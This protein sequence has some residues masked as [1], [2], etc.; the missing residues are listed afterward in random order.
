MQKLLNNI[1]TLIYSR[2]NKDKVVIVESFI[3][4]LKAKV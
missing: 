4:T 3:K 2:H 1:N